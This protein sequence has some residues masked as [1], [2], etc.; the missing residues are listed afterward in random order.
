[1]NRDENLEDEEDIC[2]PICLAV[3]RMGH[4]IKLPC[5]HVMHK[6]CYKR[7]QSK[8]HWRCPNCRRPFAKRNKK[9]RQEVT[10][11][12]SASQQ[13]NQ[14]RDTSLSPFWETIGF[15]Q[16]KN[17][18]TDVS[19]EHEERGIPVCNRVKTHATGG[20]PKSDHGTEKS[21]VDM[22]NDDCQCSEEMDDQLLENL[23]DVSF[24]RFFSSNLMYEESKE[25]V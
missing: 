8:G 11:R 13:T 16:T 12:N 18:D 24:F 14:S 7:L 3:V 5:Q 10:T 23:A 1:M 19:L 6:K 21:Y 25:I 9:C 22:C 20:C 2:C 17:D 15:G 4:E